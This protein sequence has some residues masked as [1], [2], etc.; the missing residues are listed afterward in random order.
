L[1]LSLA[2]ECVLVTANVSEFSRITDL[3]VTTWLAALDEP[4][5]VTNPT[6]PTD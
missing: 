2:H 4:A 3:R 6:A 1:P 5:P